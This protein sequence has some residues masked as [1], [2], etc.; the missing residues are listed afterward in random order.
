MVD[1][2][3]ILNEVRKQYSSDKRPWVVCYS[4]GK[5]STVLL[6][7]VFAALSTLPKAKL[8]KEIHVLTNDTLVEN[9]AIV[10]YVKKQLA[11]IETAGKENL[12]AH[13]PE[14]FKVARVT[15]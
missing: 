13:R 11:N 6:Q 10:E 14:L 7:M 5:D 4:G 3:S 8:N 1:Y 2:A 12:Y 15:P 9:P